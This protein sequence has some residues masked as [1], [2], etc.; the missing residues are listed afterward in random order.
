[1][2]LH[3]IRHV[4]TIALC[5]SFVCVAGCTSGDASS[6]DSTET[7]DARV[8]DQDLGIQHIDQHIEQADTGMDQQQLDAPSTLDVPRDSLP[9]YPSFGDPCS[10]N[11]GLC[12]DGVSTCVVFGGGS[13][14]FCSRKCTNVGSACPGGPPGSYAACLLPT[15]AGDHY[16]V[17]LCKSSSGTFTCPSQ[18]QCDSQP[19][20]PGS[21]QHACVSPKT[22]DGGFTDAA[23]DAG[24]DVAVADAGVDATPPHL[25][26]PGGFVVSAAPDKQ[27]W[28][29]VAFDGKSW[30]VVWAD[31]RTGTSYD[32]FGARVA[33]TGQVLDPNGILIA[34]AVGDQVDPKVG[35]DGSSFVVVWQDWRDAS[36]PRIYGTLVQ[37]SGQVNDVK[38]TPIGRGKTGF[39]DQHP[40]IACHASQCLVAWGEYSFNQKD[41]VLATLI[42][43]Q[44]KPTTVIEL[45]DQ[46]PAT[47]AAGTDGSSFLVVWSLDN[48]LSSGG[49]MLGG[50]VDK[51][52]AAL[53]P[54]GFVVSASSTSSKRRAAASHDGK[55][56]LVL[57]QSG[58][59]WTS[60]YDS[61]VAAQIVDNGS[62]ASSNCCYGIGSKTSDDPKPAIA[63]HG[64]LCLAAWG[65]GTYAFIDPSKPAT[66]SAAGDLGAA[67]YPAIS[68]GTNSYLVAYRTQAGIGGQRVKF[69][70]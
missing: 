65:W 37:T 13:M 17:F 3:R 42:D 30:L 39:D 68:A 12:D 23:V 43:P 56:Y 48:A 33:G 44:G 66:P 60:Q 47:T 10:N 40:S 16:C 21:S 1:M 24:V 20:P 18:L 2:T 59:G 70:P 5:A 29:D 57:W 69:A 11:L 35:F 64:N 7:P 67:D 36:A 25:L 22:I 19:N 8:P 61:I 50:R 14:G 63:C 28:P 53:D 4:G 26:D 32:I 45:Y 15:S 55:N 46:S 62:Y 9:S 27:E 49:P 52:G 51:T 38:G 54:S 41:H 31:R 34:N 58:N 6:S